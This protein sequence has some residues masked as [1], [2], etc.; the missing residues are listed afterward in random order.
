MCGL[1]AGVTGNVG[2]ATCNTHDDSPAA[3][4]GQEYPG[5]HNR[6]T[7]SSFHTL[8]DNLMN[9]FFPTTQQT[10]FYFLRCIWC[11]IWVGHVAE[12]KC[13]ALH[14]VVAWRKDSVAKVK[15]AKMTKN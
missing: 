12:V 5:W 6:G 1:P 14:E 9:S 15:M 11:H 10:Y 4:V 3:L 2:G 13:L 8:S 7:P